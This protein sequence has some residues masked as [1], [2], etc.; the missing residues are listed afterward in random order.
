[1]DNNFV[2]F[3]ARTLETFPAEAA[4]PQAP[5]RGRKRRAPAKRLDEL[6]NR[7]VVLVPPAR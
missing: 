7:A 5:T 2:N 3:D 1:M 4:A 6:D